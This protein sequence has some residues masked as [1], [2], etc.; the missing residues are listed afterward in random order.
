M[1]APPIPWI[2][3]LLKFAQ[4]KENGVALQAQKGSTILDFRS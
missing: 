1:F 4:I 3:N 2:P